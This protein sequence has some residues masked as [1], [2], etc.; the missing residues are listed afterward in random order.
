MGMACGERSEQIE[1]TAGERLSECLRALDDAELVALTVRGE[2]RAF[3][4][5]VER[6]Q[7]RLLSLVYR[8]VG[9]RE[10]AEDLVQETF[11]RLY[12][13]LRRFDA[14]RK[15][16]SWLYTIAMNLAK[17]ELRDRSRSPLV[18]FQRIRRNWTNDHRPLQFEDSSARPDEM[19]RKRQLRELVEASVSRLPA[20]Q[21]RVFVLR[22]LE[23]KSYEEIAEITG[24]N[25][26]TVKSRLN[27]ARN[28]FAALIEPA[29]DEESRFEPKLRLGTVSPAAARWRDR[30]GTT[31]G[32]A[33]R[34]APQVG[35]E[36]DHRQVNGNLRALGSPACVG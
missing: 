7:A 14:S 33:R 5:L 4:E 3:R 2:E 25:L 27:R 9:D 10:R 18:L 15:F 13:H 34:Q 17:N 24:S 22:E 21:R 19:Y 11:L 35:A 30:G 31:V 6:Y 8:I 20:Y 1:R 29:L 32:V 23:G 26:G 12:R 28:S 16:S 36:V